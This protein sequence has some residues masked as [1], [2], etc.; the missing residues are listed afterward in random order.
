MLLDEGVE[1]GA[2]G[3]V[4]EGAGE[5]GAVERHV[6]PL[7]LPHVTFTFRRYIFGNVRDVC[8]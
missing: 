2:V 8:L 1:G 5:R 3:A 7:T 4:A 6:A